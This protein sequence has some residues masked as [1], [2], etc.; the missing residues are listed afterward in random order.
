L[1]VYRRIK[2]ALLLLG[3][4]LTSVAHAEV[5]RL[6]FPSD[7]GFDL[8]WW[9]KLTA[10][11]SWEQDYDASVANAINVLV[12]KGGSFSDADT[13]MYAR[14]FF[15]E[16]PGTPP[17]LAE[18]IENDFKSH[19]SFDPSLNIAESQ[20]LKIADGTSLKVFTFFPEESGSWEKVA[21][22]EDGQFYLLFVLS[23]RTDAGYKDALEEFESAVGSYTRE[24]EE[25]GS[26]E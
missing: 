26:S 3:I 5:T 17:T 12:P 8:V 2:P 22:G 18:F 4:L 13:I 7:S 14:A 16:T 1:D 15:R 19:R 6:A 25:P 11:A 10:P 9:P 20:P 23:S 21:Y 24:P